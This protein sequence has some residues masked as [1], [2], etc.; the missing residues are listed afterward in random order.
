MLDAIDN[1]IE[2][3][4]PSRA[5]ASAMNRHARELLPA[6]DEYAPLIRSFKLRFKLRRVRGLLGQ[7]ACHTHQCHYQHACATAYDKRRYNP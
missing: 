6:C 3:E 7:S 1:A 2:V 5:S 4:I